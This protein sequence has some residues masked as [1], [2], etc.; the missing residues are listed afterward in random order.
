MSCDFKIVIKAR[1]RSQR[2][3]ILCDMVPL[4]MSLKVKAAHTQN[5]PSFFGGTGCLYRLVCIANTTVVILKVKVHVLS[6]PRF[7]LL[8]AFGS[9]FFWGKTP[10]AIL[11]FFTLALCNLVCFSG[12]CFWRLA[13]KSWV[14]NPRLNLCSQTTKKA[15]IFFLLCWI[16]TWRP[17]TSFVSLRKSSYLQNLAWPHLL[18][19]QTSP[20]SC[21]T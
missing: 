6:P 15:S 19:N 18:P 12:G 8:M 7:L 21:L 2:A 1:K 9:V 5:Q 14:K 17:R 13:K 11:F 4:L 20:L 3:L 16:K 10:Y